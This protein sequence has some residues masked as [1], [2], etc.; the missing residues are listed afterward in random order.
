MGIINVL[1]SGVGGQGIILASKILAKCAF[2]SGYMVKESELH[3]MAQRGGSVT[4]HVRFGEEVYSPLIHKGKA[5]F[6]VALEELE[7]LRY[8]FYLKTDG[9]VIL[10]RKKVVP[11]SINP[12]VA[13]YPEDVESQLKSMGFHVDSVNALEIANDLG[14]PKVENII[15]MGMLSRYMPF[16]LS[17]WEKVIKESVPVKTIDINLSAFEK[18][19]A[20]VEGKA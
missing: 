3:G 14:N 11:S 4:S 9:K 5:D 15:V 19:R 7:G 6:L 12:A 13:P 16:S 17:V 8:A 2:D 1:F 18:G 20:L 10:N